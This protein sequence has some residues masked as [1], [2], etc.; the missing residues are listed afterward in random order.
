MELKHISSL[1]QILESVII[2]FYH[3]NYATKVADFKSLF[4]YNTL[5]Q[6]MK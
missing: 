3:D 4:L 1:Y 5:T 2:H 6:I